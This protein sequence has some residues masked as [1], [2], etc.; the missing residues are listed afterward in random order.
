MKRTTKK[1]AIIIVA[2]MLSLVA[3]GCGGMETYDE[4]MPLNQI[5]SISG[6]P[7]QPTDWDTVKDTAS[8]SVTRPD[9]V[10]LE[11]PTLSSQ[12]DEVEQVDLEQQEQQAADELDDEALD[13]SSHADMSDDEEPFELR[14]R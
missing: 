14:D 11:E 2:V 6:Q 1:S 3:V 9:Q 13:T 7:G 5:E 12:L 4:G 8:D 10:D